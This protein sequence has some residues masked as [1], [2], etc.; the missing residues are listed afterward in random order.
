MT[1][2]PETKRW[3][4]SLAVFASFLALA[5]LAIWALKLTGTDRTV[6]LL[7]LVLLGAIGACVTWYILRPTEAV[8][9]AE[10]DEAQ[11]IL[12][13]AI[14]RLPRGELLRKSM[15]LVI[16]PPTSTKTTVVT[17]SGLDAQLLAGDA[18]G[19]GA[20]EPTAAANVWLTRD[21]AVVEAPGALAN[22]SAR[23]TRFMRALRAPGL[24]AALGRRAPASR[25]IV[26]C[27][28]CD[29]LAADDEGKQLDALAPTLR[30]RLAEAARELGMRV[31]VYVLFTRADRIAYFDTWASPLTREEIRVPL[32]AS[33]SFDA[34]SAGAY[35]E[36]LVPRLEAAFDALVRSL[37]ARRSDLL[38]RESVTTQR[39]AA[40]EVPREFGKLAPAAIRFLVE[41]TRPSQ[42]G[43]TPQ[44][45]GFWFTG[46]RTVVVRDA[47]PVAAVA[48]PKSDGATSVFK[49]AQ[50]AAA[51]A[52]AAA[53]T[54]ARKVPEWVFLDR[55]FSDVVL[56]DHSGRAA[57]LGG[58]RVSGMRRVLLGT[59]IFAGLLLAV[60]VLV[61][62]VGNRRLTTRTLSAARAVASLPTIQAAPGTIALPG[63]E[64]LRE[65]D[66][67]RSLL[68]TL[69]Q[70]DSA[71]PPLSLGLGLWSG[72]ALIA[73][74]RPAW[75]AGYRRQLHD[76]AWRTLVDSLRAL[77]VTPLPTSDYGRSYDM[78]KTYLV[79]STEHARSAPVFVTPVLL[80][81][82]QRG[83]VTDSTLTELARKQFDAYATMQ[84]S[85]QLWPVAAD[86]RLV[87]QARG[88]LGGYAGI[89]PIYVSMRS[90][91]STRVKPIKLAD[92][93]PQAAG[94]IATGNAMVA[95]PFTADGWHVMQ[96]ILQDSDRYFQGE[97]WV[98]GDRSAVASRNRVQDLIDIRKRF[99]SDYAGQWRAALKQLVVLRVGSVKESAARLGKLGG[100]QSPLLALFALIAHQTQVDTAL[101]RAFQ[102]V[103]TV[104][105]PAVKDKFVSEANAPYASALITLQGS[106]EQLGNLPPPTD[107]TTLAA[108]QAAALGVLMNQSQQAKGAA[109][110][111]AQTF[112]VDPD[113]QQVG[114]AVSTLL[115][116]PIDGAE[117]VLRAIGNLRPPRVAKP[118]AAAPAGGGGGG[119][120]G[121]A[122]PVVAPPAPVVAAP[123][124]NEAIASAS[125]A[126]LAVILNG[127]GRELCKAME[128]IL[129][130]FPFDPDGGDASIA[131]VNALLAPSTGALWRFYDDRL[132]PM[133]PLENRVF[134]SKPANGVTLSPPFVAFFRRMARA[135]VAL[136]ADRG[137]TPRMS[138]AVKAIPAPDLS[139]ITLVHGDRTLRWPGAETQAVSWPA[140]GG[141]NARLTI[142]S[143]GRE[144]E[145]AK[146]DGPWALFRLM[147]R[148]SSEGRGNT[149]RVTFNGN[150]PAAFEVSAPDAGPVVHR[151]ALSGQGCVS[152]VTQ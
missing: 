77:P 7:G 118:V 34:A 101:A 8:T 62:W 55:F 142:V 59:T 63:V 78:L 57:A 41:V 11:L 147:A 106:M 39:L 12:R 91:A 36:A 125:G 97:T 108:Y 119:G 49:P 45:R 109:R 87:T 102:P 71:G 21:G 29:F 121:G 139:M 123:S 146:A 15:V 152:Q 22:D 81:S 4:I 58:V 54:A 105:P 75:I 38:S 83:I 150:V 47:A 73:S 115:V 107:S 13:Q 88:H 132:A 104:T 66:H 138:L 64:A 35:S 112:S 99:L 50:I 23:F 151:G 96:G 126:D 30:A 117:G 137:Q 9:R 122:P 128:R 98:L 110:Q 90:A 51:A 5:V 134:V 84:A 33:L 2:R 43:M 60:G 26:L 136:Y 127:R 25:A 94:V 68:D 19:T 135:S 141:N 85:A 16:G 131:D 80:A 46:A 17:R 67:L 56:A 129:R 20:E 92:T 18:R 40:Y 53:A 143:G 103:H 130:K 65:L 93:V 10:K 72:K 74:A 70:I 95:A 100:A 120:G 116:A 89:D 28:P 42:M 82:W 37:A 32:G 14:D 140:T 145:L 3:L 24:A 48:G 86:A 113:A 1:L 111:L 124:G 133:L 79:G 52:G 6:L 148:G 31:P 44:L 61:S 144:Q 114:P 149:I 27:V 69:A 76:D